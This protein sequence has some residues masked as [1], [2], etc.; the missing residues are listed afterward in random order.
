MTESENTR[1]ENV[2]NSDS[3]LLFTQ[4]SAVELVDER[5]GHWREPPDHSEGFGDIS[6]F[7]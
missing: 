2:V 6:V 7:A 4:I 3:L 1:I 5:V